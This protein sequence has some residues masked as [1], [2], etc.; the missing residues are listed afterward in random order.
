MKEQRAPF[1]VG[2]VVVRWREE[3]GGE[4]EASLTG[5]VSIVIEVGP[6][7]WR[8]NAQPFDGYPIKVLSE[9]Y[10]DPDWFSD[11]SDFRLYEPPKPKSKLTDKKTEKTKERT[12]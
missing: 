9:R 4:C 7:D 10:P 1:W 5:T 11:S 3:R 12:E 8:T 2:D 6:P